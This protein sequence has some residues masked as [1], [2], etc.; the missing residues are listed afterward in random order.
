MYSIRTINIAHFSNY[1]DAWMLAY[2]HK[3][4]F[5]SIPD[6]DLKNVNVNVWLSR[7]YGLDPANVNISGEILHHQLPV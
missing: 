6:L 7:P 4:T 1:S 5:C 2:I 3:H